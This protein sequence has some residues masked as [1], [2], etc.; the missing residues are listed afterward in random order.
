MTNAEIDSHELLDAEQAK[1]CKVMR[2]TARSTRE[3]FTLLNFA[4]IALR[5]EARDYT[6]AQE[7]TLSAQV[8]ADARLRRAAILYVYEALKASDVALI[9]EYPDLPEALDLLTW[10]NRDMP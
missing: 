9:A 10:L 5:A 1:L 7:L 3:T 2:N 6:A 8:I 4:E